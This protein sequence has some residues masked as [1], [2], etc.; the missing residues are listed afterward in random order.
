MDAD[1]ANPINLTHHPKFDSHAAW[2][3]DGKKIAFVSKR[4]DNAEIYVMDADGANPI[5]LTHHPALDGA[6]AWSPDGKK[7][8]FMSKRDGNAGDLRHGRRRHQSGQDDA[9]PGDRRFTHLVESQIEPNERAKPTV[10]P[11]VYAVSLR[12]EPDQIHPHR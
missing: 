9:Q 6:P 11:P 4:D 10:L 3:P 2:S 5:N 12:R 1:G 7:I 8:A